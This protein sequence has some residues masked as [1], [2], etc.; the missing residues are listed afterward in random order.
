[1]KAQ[2]DL[3]IYFEQYCMNNHKWSCTKYEMS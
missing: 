1:M 2:F 3:F